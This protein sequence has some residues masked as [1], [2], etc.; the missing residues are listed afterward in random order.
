[1]LSGQE[2]NPHELLPLQDWEKIFHGNVK[3]YSGQ[4]EG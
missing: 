2:D 4:S 1:M 3:Y